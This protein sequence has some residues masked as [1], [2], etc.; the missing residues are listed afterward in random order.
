M[1]RRLIATVLIVSI[2]L[3]TPGG[4]FYE[5]CAQTIAASAARAGVPGAAAG[6]IGT[7]RLVLPTPSLSGS[8]APAALRPALSV[9]SA[10]APLAVAAPL[11]A[12]SVPGSA[13]AAVAAK[14]VS[15]PAAVI[16]AAVRP[17]AAAPAAAGSFKH[18][19]TGEDAG[20]L[21]DQAFARPSALDDVLAAPSAESETPSGLEPAKIPAGGAPAQPPAPG[22]AKLPRSMWGLFWGHHITTVFGVNFHVLSQAFL[23][24]DTLGMGTATMGL[25]RNIHMGSMAVVNLLPIGYLIDKTDYRVVFIATSLARAALMAAIPL[26]FMA[27]GLHFTILALIVAVNPIFQS[28]MIVADGAARKSFLGK[29]EKLNKDAAATLG[30]WDSVAGMLMPIIA[31]WAVGAMVTSLGLGGYAMAYGVYGALLIASIPFYWFM[32]RDS[33]FPDND[34]MGP[35]GFGAQIVTFMGA[36]LASVAH[37]FTVLLNWSFN[38]FFSRTRAEFPATHGARALWVGKELLV[39]LAGA[40]LL[41]PALLKA[42]FKIPGAIK[43]ARAKSGIK[44][45]SLPEILDGYKQLEGVAFILRNRTL[46]ILT[47]VMALEVLLIDALPFVL[48]PSLITDAIGKAPAALSVPLWAAAIPAGLALLA[49]G[50]R[51][52]TKRKS[53]WPALVLGAVAATVAAVSFFP[54]LLLAQVASAG[55]IMGLL[56]SLEYIGRFIPSARLEGEKGDAI[57]A[58]VGHGRFYRHAAF[59]SLLFWALLA[60]VYLT[61]G[62]FWLNLAIIA[63]VLFTVQY[64][65]APVGIVMEPVKRAE[66]DDDKLARIESAVFMI[67][68]AFESV[69]ALFLGLLLD[70]AG[71]APALIA[72][73]AF[74]TIT[75]VLQYNVPKWIFKDGNHPDKKPATPPADPQAS[76]SVPELAFA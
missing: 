44:R 31:G 53:W 72:T 75:A 41:V 33:R 5:V 24:K 76:L 60:P 40:A 58:K 1:M 23:V 36:L 63:G 50:I 26:L 59:A 9:L 54:G 67:D 64:F 8:F 65:H 3:L 20:A 2:A 68:V 37:P 45:R 46:R 71:L 30:K 13:P 43:A 48:I 22:R 55:S 14:A 69:G 42:L 49:A 21:F 74:L 56:F 51:A 17:V 35:L 66:M 70:F 62:M 39:A 34:K 10:P 6:S 25:V 38:S 19:K 15:V 4:R 57:I 11:A 16:G 73:A 12:L 47:A 32:I 29:D 52:V 7:V 27:G 18:A 28:V 61:G